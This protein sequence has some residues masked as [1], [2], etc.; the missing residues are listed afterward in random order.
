MPTLELIV[1]VF[2][3][4]NEQIAQVAYQVFS[5]IIEGCIEDHEEHAR[6]LLLLLDGALNL[7]SV[8]VWKF[9]LRFGQYFH[10]EFSF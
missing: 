5:R 6:R 1:K 2:E 7:Q 10:K 3:S 8:L 9:I 4:A